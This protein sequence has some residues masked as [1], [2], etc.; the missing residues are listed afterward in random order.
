MNN[1]KEKIINNIYDLIFLLQINDDN[2]FKIKAWQNALEIINNLDENLLSNQEEL[3][4]IKGIGKGIQSFIKES[5]MQEPQD[6]ILLKEKI[7]L[8]LQELTHING[9]GIKRIKKLWQELDIKNLGELEYACQENR[10]ALL[11][12]FGEKIQ[13]SILADISQYNSN[14]KYLRLD[15]ALALSLQITE[16]LY[17]IGCQKVETAY[18]LC[19]KPEIIDQLSFV[20]LSKDNLTDILSKISTI[21]NIQIQNN[22]IIYNNILINLFICKEDNNFGL[23]MLYHTSPDNFWQLLQKRATEL[24]INLDKQNIFADNEQDIF[25]LLNI[26][27][28][29]AEY[30]HRTN[31]LV[32]KNKSA[33]NLIKLTDL[34]GAFHNHTIASDGAHSIEDMRIK[35]IDLGLKYISI[36][37]HSTQAVY[38]NGLMANDLKAQ[39]KKISKLNND[40]FGQKCF[41]FSGTESDILADGLLDYD[42]DLLKMLDIIIASVHT[43][44][45][46]NSKDM[47]NRLITALSN[48]YTTI[49][50]HPS[51]RLLLSRKAYEFDVEK[52]FLAAKNNNV[53]LELNANPHRLDINEDMLVLAKELSIPICINADAHTK[54][55]LKD[56]EYGIMMAKRA[57]LRSD[58]VLNCRSLDDI[59]QWLQSRKSKGVL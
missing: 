31:Y 32:T 52:V 40:E 53:A 45:K 1:I 58:D 17:S 11:K 10:L 2:I 59:K 16:I 48:P 25:D 29:E 9:L 51:G 30:R 21:K 28:V 47:T 34:Q 18:P 14:K 37:D 44:F 22:K 50:G 20:I 6:L 43:R 7:P 19:A 46:Q 56:L 15:E 13:A 57:G 3:S 5:L 26:F 38:A 41:I 42:D 39:I 54:D 55:G 35:A 27:Y 8:S 24:S 4:K 23:T 33:K 12:G 49:L 36:N